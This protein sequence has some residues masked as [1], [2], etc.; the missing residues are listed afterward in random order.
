MPLHFRTGWY[1]CYTQ[2]RVSPPSRLQG[3][4]AEGTT[5]EHCLCWDHW[6]SSTL[7]PSPPVAP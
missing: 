3:E 6:L 1:W 4:S 7:A 2:P 5:Q